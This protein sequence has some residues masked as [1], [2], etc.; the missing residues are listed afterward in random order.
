[1]RGWCFRA[2]R[3]RSGI[4]WQKQLLLVLAAVMVVV[5]LLLL[6]QELVRD[7]ICSMI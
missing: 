4:S 7:Y 3:R 5:L 2:A 1:L 6:L